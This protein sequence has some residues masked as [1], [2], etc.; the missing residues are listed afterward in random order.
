VDPDRV[1]RLINPPPTTA[2]EE[3]AHRRTALGRR[4][5]AYGVLLQRCADWGD[6]LRRVMAVRLA[7]LIEFQSI[8]YANRY[9]DV[10]ARVREQ[11]TARN[12]GED[13]TMAVACNLFK[14]YAYKDEYEVARLHLRDTFRQYVDDTFADS[15]R[16]TFHLAPPALRRFRGG[17]KVSVPGRVARPMFGVL[18][19]L[20]VLR[21]HPWDPFG[22]QHSR[23]VDRDV[24]DWYEALVTEAMPRLS[25]LTKP[26][27]LNLATL[28]D[29]IRGYEELK[30]RSFAAAREQGEKLV[31][32][33]DRPY[34][35][36]ISS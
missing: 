6:P 10:V 29:D 35:P 31:A 11:E 17:A 19:R 16:L 1:R 30:E 20:R 18:R 12:S 4:G 5:P 9:L 21:G 22:R 25:P 28:P 27:L 14:V 33:L 13:V 34:L 32:R 26:M 24:R 7:E 3:S 15:G 8:A 23:R 2:D 36:L